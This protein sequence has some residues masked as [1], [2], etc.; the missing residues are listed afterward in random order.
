MYFIVFVG[1]VPSRLCL[2]GGELFGTLQTERTA[3]SRSDWKDL[4][5]PSLKLNREGHTTRERGPQSRRESN[6]SELR[7]G[8]VTEGRFFESQRSHFDAHAPCRDALPPS[9]ASSVR[10]FISFNPSPPSGARFA[11]A[12]NR[13]RRRPTRDELRHIEHARAAMAHDTRKSATCPRASTPTTSHET[14][15]VFEERIDYV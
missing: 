9:D 12:P 2:H 3:K 14:G 8:R 10:A 7:L 1:V 13:H 6:A 5:S 11:D 4:D 15:K